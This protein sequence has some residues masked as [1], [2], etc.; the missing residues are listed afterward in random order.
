[1]SCSFCESSVAK[2]RDVWDVVHLLCQIKTIEKRVVVLRR[3]QV[4]V[5]A[6]YL[7]KG[8]S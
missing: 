3:M 1:M 8:H 7:V 6:N 4:Y 5:I 2:S